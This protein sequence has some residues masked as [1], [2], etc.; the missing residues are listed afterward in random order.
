ML[1]VT[2]SALDRL[3]RRLARKEAAD[4]VAL[5]FSRR[6]GGWSLRMD[7][8]AAGDTAIDHDGRTVLLLD[9]SVSKVPARCVT[10]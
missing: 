6:D 4:G 8:A 7:E 9:E 10:V 1:T 2:N 5:R 3:H